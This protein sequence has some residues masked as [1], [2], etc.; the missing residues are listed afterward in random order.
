MIFYSSKDKL[1]FSYI[2]NCDCL[3]QVS[4]DMNTASFMVF[5]SSPFH[6][7][8]STQDGYNMGFKKKEFFKL[9][10]KRS[11]GGRTT[12]SRIQRIIKLWVLKIN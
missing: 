11:G 4:S 6:S 2:Q 9:S 3:R 8:S 5:V 12:Y 1:N 10:F 7:F